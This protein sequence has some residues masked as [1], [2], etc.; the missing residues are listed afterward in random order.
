MSSEIHADVVSEG[1]RVLAAARDAG[2]TVRLLGGVAV[3]VRSR[4]LPPS[5]AREYK[6]LDFA[7]PKKSSGDAR[8]KL[9][10]DAGYEPH[11]AFNAMH[12]R[13]RRLFFDDPTS[14]QVDVFVGSF[15]MCHEIPLDEAPRASTRTRCRSPSCC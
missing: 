3:R 5:L 4:G 12:A 9:L 8:Q 14:R 2:L 1:R 13:E 10:R 15:R 11:V 6:D 7:I